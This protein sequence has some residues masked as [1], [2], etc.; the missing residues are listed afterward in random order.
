VLAFQ[1][2]LEADAFDFNDF[3]DQFKRMN[4][5]GGLQVGVVIVIII[6]LLQPFPVW[7]VNAMAFP[8]WGPRA[9]Q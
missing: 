7:V 5:M 4:N 9:R 1:R 2:R 6:M 8:P 3:L